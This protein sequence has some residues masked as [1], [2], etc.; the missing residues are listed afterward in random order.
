MQW[1][2]HPTMRDTL[3]NFPSKMDF[4]GFCVITLPSMTG[5][6]ML[7]GLQILVRNDQARD[8]GS[9]YTVT[10]KSETASCALASAL[11]DALRKQDIVF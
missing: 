1:K 11:T 7:Y 10:L 8:A 9:T 4:V 3:W 6:K 5:V 2:T